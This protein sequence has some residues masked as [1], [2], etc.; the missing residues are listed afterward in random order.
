MEKTKDL[1]YLT[2][3]VR[4]LR[5]LAEAVGEKSSPGGLDGIVNDTEQ[6]FQPIIEKAEAL[7]F[8]DTEYPQGGYPVPTT[9][10]LQSLLEQIKT[11]VKRP[12][13]FQ[14]MMPVT[15]KGSFFPVKDKDGRGELAGLWKKIK[16][17]IESL[18]QDDTRVLAENILNVL[19][20]FAVT[21][22]SSAKCQDVSLYDQT[23]VAASFAV[24]LYELQESGETPKD[25]ELRLIGG[26]FSGIQ[27]Y[28]YQIVSKYASK[29]LKGRS[30]YI[31]LLSD[32]VVRTLLSELSLYRANIVYNSGGCFYLLAPNTTEIKAALDK[33]VKNIEKNIFKA[34]GTQLYV[35]I[36][37]IALKVEEASNIGGVR[38]LSEIW[39]ELFSRRDKKKNCR[40]ADAMN[41][42]YDAFFTPA[43]IDGTKRDAIT[44][45]DFL[46]EEKQVK[47]VDDTYISAL[48]D[49]QI[50]LG[51]ALMSAD[52]L[53]VSEK[54]LDF[55]EGKTHIAP[56]GLDLTYYLVHFRDIEDNI[57]RVHKQGGEL[58][59]V[60]LNGEDFKADYVVDDYLTYN[61][62][63]MQFYGGNRFNGNTYEEMCENDSFSRLGVLRMDVDNLGSI[64][65]GGIPKEKASLSRYAA[66]SRSFDYFFSGYL[67]VICKEYGRDDASFI[68]Y[69]GGDDV[70]IV[71]SWD[72]TI[73]IAK[74]IQ[75]DFHRFTCFNPAFSISGGIAILGAKFPII[76]G[77]EESAEEEELA[78]E[79]VC[80]EC[81][82]DSV[83]FFSLPLN[84]KKEFP[85]VEQ[86]KDEISELLESDELPKSFLSKIMEHAMSA[87]IKNHKVSNFKV[88][89]HLAYDLKR[90]K[91]RYKKFDRT[92]ALLDKCVSEVCHSSG[93][94]DG[95]KIETSYNSLELWAFACRWA[96][97]DFRANKE[98]N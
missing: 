85:A 44:G 42:D 98:N 29:N 62:C 48:N 71:G 75:S 63:S 13:Y 52:V 22:P 46:P 64:F 83:S 54:P 91:E 89:W 59:L 14:P 1:L 95:N 32:A 9:T 39:Q 20:R 87:G 65:Q 96:E 86:L 68:I 78:K 88:Y 84:W 17:N 2:M 18:K 6:K 73:E 77:A 19:F 72:V 3:L 33:T 74:Q 60:M 12:E 5:R 94:L 37:S 81:K 16:E 80:G 38:T 97:L 61:I 43:K 21:I 53:A 55:F 93:Q 82:K 66:L 40:Y 26:D 34:H 76:A 8:G 28:I 56:A 36:D 35:A 25:G 10:R 79:H 24:C 92:V 11:N 45:E 49:T 31:N 30:F 47:F 70:F 7:S 27:K 50:K 69:S 51:K 15:L 58:S 90:M 23:R 4:P 67:N 57:D 41:N